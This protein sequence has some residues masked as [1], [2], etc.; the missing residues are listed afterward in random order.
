MFGVADSIGLGEVSWES[1]GLAVEGDFVEVVEYKCT[2]YFSTDRFS[3][4][5]DHIIEW[6]REI[7]LANRKKSKKE[8]Y[9]LL[10]KQSD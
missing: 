10:Y 3:I 8:T 4:N 1:A 5:V 2:S 6:K 7:K 9:W